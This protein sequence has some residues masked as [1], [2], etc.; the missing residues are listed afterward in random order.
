MFLGS[1]HSWQTAR[2]PHAISAKPVAKPETA[3]TARNAKLSGAFAAQR[4]STRPQFVS[5]RQAAS[6]LKRMAN[7][8]PRQAGWVKAA[9]RPQSLALIRPGWCGSESKRNPWTP[10]RSYPR[11]PARNA[12]GSRVSN[13]D[14]AGRRYPSY[15]RRSAS[16]SSLGSIAVAPIALRIWRIDLR[17]ASRKARLPFSIRCQRSATC[18][19]CGRAVAAASP[20]QRARLGRCRGLTIRQRPDD[21]APFHVA[22]DAGV[23]V[24]APPSPNHQC[25]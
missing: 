11:R 3:P 7:P 23:S 19:A 1:Q 4:A 17:T 5:A 24:I 6:R 16:V 8:S 25:R 18:T 20:Y 2:T 13:S 22:D 9:Q 21:P 15:C 10:G 14:A 12:P